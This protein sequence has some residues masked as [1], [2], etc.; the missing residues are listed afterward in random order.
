M[1]KTNITQEF[2]FDLQQAVKSQFKSD[3]LTRQLY[4]TDASCYQVVPAGVLIPRDVDDVIAAIEIANHHQVPLVPRGA[5]T[6]LS[7]QSIGPGLIIDHSRY[8]DR[9]LEIN[10]EESWVKVESG[11][12]L[13]KL[14][15]A[16]AFHGLMVG[17][18]PASSAMATIGGIT[19]NNSSGMHSIKYGKVSDHIRESLGT[20]YLQ[21]SSVAPAI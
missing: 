6:S 8:I 19:G 17:P 10:P 15:F 1:L 3:P 5:G 12:V 4:S 18:D 21:R 11:Q 20:I 14:N 7:G 13:G 9:I 2:I 16:L